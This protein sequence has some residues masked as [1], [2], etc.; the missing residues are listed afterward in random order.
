MPSQKY[1]IVFCTVNMQYPNLISSYSHTACSTHQEKLITFASKKFIIVN[2]GSWSAVS[3]LHQNNSS[4]FLILPENM[5]KCMWD[6]VAQGTYGTIRTLIWKPLRLIKTIFLLT[7]ANT[8]HTSASGAKTWF[9]HLRV[10][11]S[12]PYNVIDNLR[13]V[14]SLRGTTT[15]LP[16]WVRILS[17]W[18]EVIPN[19]LHIH[20]QLTKKCFSKTRCKEEKEEKHTS[21]KHI[22]RQPGQE[23]R[24]FNQQSVVPQVKSTL[25]IKNLH[26][27][28]P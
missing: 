10:K 2:K 23:M 12:D 3:Q 9:T 1:K 7:S 21:N 22:W 20:C 27:P 26:L 25:T 14:T 19:A 13:H 15:I 16:T 5:Y 28:L 4:H 6:N 17:L 18:N 24:A 11:L 8:D